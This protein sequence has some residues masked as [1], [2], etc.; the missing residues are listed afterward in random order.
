MALTEMRSL[1]RR[2]ARWRDRDEAHAGAT[3]MMGCWL[4]EMRS[5]TRR[6]ARWRDREDGLLA[7]DTHMVTNIE[8]LVTEHM[9]PGGDQAG[10]LAAMRGSCY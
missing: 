8:T 2:G 10:R 6:S 9:E 5:L 7:L 4:T 3:E 1:T